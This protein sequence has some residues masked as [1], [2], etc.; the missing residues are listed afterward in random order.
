VVIFHHHL[1]ENGLSYFA[2]AFFAGNCT[3]ELR[4]K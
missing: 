2:G 3:L 1:A 4:W